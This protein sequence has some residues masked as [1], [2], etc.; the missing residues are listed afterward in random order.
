[1][2]REESLRGELRMKIERISKEKAFWALS[3]IQSYNRLRNDLDAYLYEVAEYGMALRS[4]IPDIESFRIEE[5]NRN[6]SR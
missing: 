5:I 4:T 3:T 6:H 2:Q 1:M